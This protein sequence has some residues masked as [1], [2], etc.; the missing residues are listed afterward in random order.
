MSDV[1]TDFSCFLSALDMNT[2][3]RTIILEQATSFLGAFAKLR[4][5]IISCGM[6]VRPS[7]CMEHLGFH[8]TDFCETW[9][10]S[11]FRKS[12]EKIQDIL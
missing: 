11:N 1:L 2:R 12:F 8:W 10:L 5:T 9:Y 4:K 6:S 7:V 3:G